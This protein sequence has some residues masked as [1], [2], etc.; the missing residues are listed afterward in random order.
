MDPANG[1]PRE[2]DAES[3]DVVSDPQFKWGME[4]LERMQLRGDE[5][6]LDAGCG[7]GRVTEELLERLP[8]G[9]MLAVDASRAMIEKARER[10]GDRASYLVVDLAELEVDEQ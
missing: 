1:S 3:Y 10:L 4:V 8:D 2:W 5:Y 6:V 9:R 7:S